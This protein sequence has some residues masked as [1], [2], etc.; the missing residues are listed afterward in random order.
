[1]TALRIALIGLGTLVA[2]YGGYVLVTRQDGDNLLSAGTWLVGGVVLHDAVLAPLTLAVAFVA[3]RL[4]AAPWRLP[5]TVAL[6]V[7][8]PLTL[9][10][11]PVLGRFGA[12]EDNPTL[13]D[14]PYLASW[15][16][17]VAVAALTVAVVGWVRAR[18]PAVRGRS[19]EE[20]ADGTRTRR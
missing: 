6:V 14:R 2:A 17:L 4:L 19:G 8:A 16:V 18:G 3:V 7:L 13:L 1:M 11:V 15:L 9:L 20:Q 12:L 5:A 10:A